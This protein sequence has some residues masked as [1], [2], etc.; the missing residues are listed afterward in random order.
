[1][2][3]VQEF[4]KGVD[5]KVKDVIYLFFVR[6][7]GLFFK[8]LLLK[9]VWLFFFERLKRFGKNKVVFQFRVEEKFSVKISIVLELVGFRGE[10]LVF[11][12]ELFEVEISS[13]ELF[14]DLLRFSFVL[15][16]VQ[17]YYFSIFVGFFEW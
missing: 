8:Q 10:F 3:L 6:E 15:V 7:F 14:V 5:N 9:F 16:V 11:I 4:F 13:V 12:V 2:V 17:D 1:M